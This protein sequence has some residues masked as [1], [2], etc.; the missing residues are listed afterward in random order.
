MKNFIFKSPRRLVKNSSINI[1]GIVL[2]KVS[3][4]QDEQRH[5]RQDLADIKLM[6]NKLLINKHLEQQADEYFDKDE[7]PPEDL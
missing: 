3:T 5:Q 1:M 2:F 4:I 6:L 7:E